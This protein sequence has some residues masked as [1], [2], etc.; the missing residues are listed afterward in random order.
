MAIPADSPAAVLEGVEPEVAQLGDLLAG[1]PDAEDA[2]G[3]LGSL[4][5]EAGRGSADHHRVPR[6][7]VS[8]T[9]RPALPF[10]VDE[11]DDD[12]GDEQPDHRADDG[13]QP[14]LGGDRVPRHVRRETT[15]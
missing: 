2:A 3:I 9:P 13:K 5:R 1:S 8:H 14:H 6:A 7:P 15:A 10:A 11:G 12:A 4:H